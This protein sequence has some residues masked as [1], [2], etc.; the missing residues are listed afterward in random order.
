VIHHRLPLKIFVLNNSGYLSMRM[1]QSDLGRLT[2]ESAA[3]GTS[4]PNM[5]KIGSPMAFHPFAS[6]ARTQLDQVDRAHCSRWTALIDVVSIPSGIRARSKA[7][8]LP[9][10]K[11]VSPTL[12]DMYPFPDNT[13]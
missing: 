8:Q 13:D 7:R 9:D 11:I 10:G 4:F 6:T 2:G 3:T 12:E 5:V 1:T